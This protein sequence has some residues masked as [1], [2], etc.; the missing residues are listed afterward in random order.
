M[1]ID[2]ELIARKN[3]LEVA[4]RC[5]VT[6]NS[7]NVYRVKWL[8]SDDWDGLDKRCV[9][10]AGMGETITVEL[11]EDGTCV[12]PWETMTESGKPL[13]A[14]VYGTK[15]EDVVLPTVWSCLG[16]I[17]QG[18]APGDAGRP[19]TPDAWQ[20]LKDELTGA[21][22]QAEDSSRQAGEHEQAA[23]EYART[24][25][26]YSGNSPI[27][28]DDEWWTWDAEL[29]K[30]VNTGTRANGVPGPQGPPGAIV[31]TTGTYGFHVDENGDLI[32]HYTGD[33]PPAFSLNEGDGHLY[34]T[35]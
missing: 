27:I 23:E 22:R 34:I 35:L 10:R 32:L 29:Q 5:A 33:E 21:A 1:N 26:E 30:Y 12:I 31:T 20:E 11:G 17:L 6:S 8:F 13:F 15:G 25:R 3:L 16:N 19:P 7:V 4:K 28:R 9:F 18:T 2:F 24:A 14:G